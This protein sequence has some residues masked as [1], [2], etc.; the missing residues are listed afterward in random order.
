MFSSLHKLWRFWPERT[1]YVLLG[2]GRCFFTRCDLR[3]TTITEIV[4]EHITLDFRDM[5]V[6]FQSQPFTELLWEGVN[7]ENADLWFIYFNRTPFLMVQL[8]TLKVLWKHP[9]LLA[10]SCDFTDARFR[11]TGTKDV[12]CRVPVS[13]SQSFQMLSSVEGGSGLWLHGSDYKCEQ[14]IVTGRTKTEGTTLTM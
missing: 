9:W 5:R 13:I 7:A 1:Q 2:Y 6:W 8:D 10:R 12:R 3:K 4:V 14:I 11:E